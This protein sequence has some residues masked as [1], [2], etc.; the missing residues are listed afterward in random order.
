MGGQCENFEGG[1]GEGEKGEGGGKR[2]GR[3]RGVRWRP[4][5]QLEHGFFRILAHIRNGSTGHEVEEG[6]DEG[7]ALAQDVVGFTAVGAEVAVVGAVTAPHGLHHG[8]AQ[9]HGGRE[10]LGVTPCNHSCKALSEA[11]KGSCSVCTY[12]SKR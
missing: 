5:L 4:N 10:R 9:L 7:G 1:G 11:G 2:E 6:Q 8:S 3:W 12:S